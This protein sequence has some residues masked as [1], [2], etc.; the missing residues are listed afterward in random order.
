M[1]ADAAEI[2]RTAARAALDVAGVAGLQP[3]LRRR[4]AN[5]AARARRTLGSPVPSAPAGVHAERAPEDGGWHIDV[6]CV[7]TE[8][9]RA[10]D[11]ARDIR[12]RVRSAVGAQLARQ[13]APETVSVT[14]TVAGIAAPPPAGPSCS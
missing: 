9:R 10:L 5:A 14:V 13:G 7:L 3:G 11:A 2:E 8:E 1:T 4:L 6:R 12:D